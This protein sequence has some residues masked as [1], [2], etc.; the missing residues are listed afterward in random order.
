MVPDS[1]PVA[2]THACDEPSAFQD[3]LV[4]WFRREGQ[5]YPWRE[6]TDPYAILVSEFMLQQTQIATVLNRGYYQRWLNQ[7]PDFAALA[8]ATEDD[9][10]RAWE[11]LGYYRRARNL[12]R[13]AQVV[14][15]DH[16]GSMPETLED[17]LALPGIGRYTAGAV[18]SFAHDQSVPLVDG[19]VLRVFARLFDYPHEVD[20][21][22]GQKQM[23]SWAETLV[24]PAH[25]RHYNAGL[26]ELGQ[27]ICLQ[28]QPLCQECPVS[29]FCRTR[30]PE[31]LPRKTK[32]RS[33]VF[34]DEHVLFLLEGDRL[35]LV[36]ENG[37]RRQ[38]LWKLPECSQDGREKLALLYKAKYSITH[39][40]VTLHVYGGP[41]RS[42][43]EGSWVSLAE[44]PALAMASPYRK[45]VD[46]LL[47]DAGDFQLNS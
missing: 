43:V 46:Q 8:E 40:R 45:A 29:R 14:V 31:E 39:H 38:G 16:G 22:E 25:A 11:G 47:S 20:Q 15:A 9:V 32:R 5:S 33:T 37:R 41:G 23:W 26:M 6:T 24:P 2:Q 7:F 13:L 12:H 44:V 19:N 1:K 36:Q 3:A 42:G 21:T 34:L 17:I 30:R 35:L 27:R 28:K 18:L 10:L 4:G